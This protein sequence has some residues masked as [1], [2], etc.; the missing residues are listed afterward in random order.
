[1]R[2]WKRFKSWLRR[3]LRC[4]LGFH[5]EWNI[6]EWGFGGAAVDWYCDRCQAFIGFTALDDMSPEMKTAV[7]DRWGSPLFD[8]AVQ[9]PG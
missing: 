4:K 3:P 2:R 5:A 8:G 6:D 1:M 9:F 7:E